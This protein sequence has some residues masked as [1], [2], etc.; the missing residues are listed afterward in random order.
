[1]SGFNGEVSGKKYNFSQGV[2]RFD[3][4]GEN[5]EFLGRTSNN[6]WGLGFSEDFET[7]ISTANGQHSV[8]LALDSK[9]AK[10]TVY[11]GTPNTATGID[12]HYDMPHI[13]PFLRQVDW[14]GSYTAAAG[15]NLYTARNFP[16]EYWNKMAFVAE[17]TGRV[18]HNARLIEEG[19]G[20]REKNAFNI[21]ASSDEWFSPVHAEVGPDG[22]LWVADWYNFIIQ[23]NPTPRGF[24]NGEGNA[25]INPMRDKKHGRI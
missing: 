9:Y 23:H 12:S 13:T 2:Y 16:E 24:E 5:L 11:K 4:S 20:Y 18:L 25:Y 3:T 10:R 15:H 19:S 8:Y 7:F 21:L 1:Y 6:T 14:H 17:P 22:S